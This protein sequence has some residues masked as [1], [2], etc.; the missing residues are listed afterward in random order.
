MPCEPSS[1][2]DSSRSAPT[3]TFMRYSTA[4]CGLLKLARMARMT[5]SFGK[6]ILTISLTEV[7]SADPIKNEAGSSLPLDEAIVSGTAAGALVDCDGVSEGD[8]AAVTELA[9]PGALGVATGGAWAGVD[10]TVVAAEGAE[11][12]A[13][14]GAA[15]GA[16]TAGAALGFET[17]TTQNWTRGRPVEISFATRVMIGRG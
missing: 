5:C 10:G 16:E 2:C 4:L 17:M 3:L 8:E 6:P 14:A 1:K 13:A 11:V 7:S 9:G 12:E 15:A